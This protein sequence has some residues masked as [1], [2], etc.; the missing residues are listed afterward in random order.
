MDEQGN[1]VADSIVWHWPSY[2]FSELVSILQLNDKQ[3]E[4]QW[5][6]APRKGKKHGNDLKP[7]E[8]DL[9][10]EGSIRCLVD[11]MNA[12]VN[13]GTIVQ[14]KDRFRM[15][16]GDNP[17]FVSSQNSVIRLNEVLQT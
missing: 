5:R 3:I 1:F 14:I 9:Q 4:A 15:P 13:N 17:N 12:M 16:Y 8:L 10:C 11:E 2:T 7:L 6:K